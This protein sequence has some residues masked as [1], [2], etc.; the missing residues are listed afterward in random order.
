MN[1]R[2]HRSRTYWRV[3]YPLRRLRRS[4][5]YGWD[6]SPLRRRTDR[7]EGAVIAGLIVAFLIAAPL[8]ARAAGSWTG[9]GGIREE[10]A[11]AQ[12]KLVPATLE[13]A[14]PPPN[15]YRYDLAPVVREPARWTAPDGQPSNGL[16]PSPPDAA[17]GSRTY[18]WVTW[19]GRLTSAPLS[20]SQLQ[21]RI[22]LTEILVVCG[23]AAAVYLVGWGWRLLLD[24]RRRA[25]WEAAWRAAERRWPQQR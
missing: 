20:P 19:T 13:H 18:V 11:E 25:R 6:R 21:G 14:A 12:W 9:A 8:L 5:V 10:H 1:R 3:R 2:L 17:A 4:R 15:A 16:I 7:F 22:V 24:R 23:L